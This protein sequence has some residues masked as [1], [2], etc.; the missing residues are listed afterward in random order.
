VR[1]CAFELVRD[2]TGAAPT[3][4]GSSLGDPTFRCSA[5]EVLKTGEATPR[6]ITFEIIKGLAKLGHQLVAER[7]QGLGAIEANDADT[8]VARQID[9]GKS[10]ERKF[11]DVVMRINCPKRA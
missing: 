10:H 9:G 8:P 5:P 4:T 2:L 3:V 6:G 1:L 11:P 7:I